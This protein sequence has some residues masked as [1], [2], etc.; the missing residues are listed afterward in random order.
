MSRGKLACTCTLLFTTCFAEA[1]FAG[2]RTLQGKQSYQIRQGSA[3]LR[4][5]FSSLLALP[6]TKEAKRLGRVCTSQ[7][8]E[9][10]SRLTVFIST[11]VEHLHLS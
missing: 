2:S 6:S 4:L 8:E 1:A 9:K 11:D 5:I 10:L 3:K 7:P